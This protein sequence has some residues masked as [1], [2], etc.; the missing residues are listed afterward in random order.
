[1]RVLVTGAS[2]F[3]GGALL[4]RLSEDRSFVPIG[5][6]R[7]LARGVPSDIQLVQVDSLGPTTDWKSVVSNIDAIV[8]TAARVHVMRESSSDPLASFRQV[9]VEGSRRL[10]EQAAESGV[11]RLVF[12]SSIKVNGEQ[13]SVHRPFRASDDPAPTD[14]YAISKREA[15]AAILAVAEK[16]E[17]EAVIV[18]PPLV[19]GPGVKANF[20]LL[21]KWIYRGFP[22]PLANVQNRRSMLALG[23]L[24]Q[25]LCCCLRSP[26]AAN[27]VFLASDGDDLSTT[28]LLQQIGEALSSPPR[29]F[30]MSPRLL[31]YS[32]QLVGRGDQMRRLLE[33]LRVDSTKTRDVL[34]WRPEIGVSQ[35]IRATADAFVSEE[36]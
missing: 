24:V 11:K 32:A 15:E 20:R 27:Q 12:L 21:M 22:L 33:S 8:H 6:V 35:G 2:G 5:A 9:N 29:L 34:G 18:R 25:L 4:R 36:E 19:Y 23:N 14:A 26:A 13:T 7:S 16:S 10:A 28:E 31:R 1:M 30:R 3:I 17:M